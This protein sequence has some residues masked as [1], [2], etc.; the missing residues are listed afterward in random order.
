MYTSQTL[1]H[2]DTQTLREL[3]GDMLYQIGLLLDM[4]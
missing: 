1:R 3:N 2:S 4:E